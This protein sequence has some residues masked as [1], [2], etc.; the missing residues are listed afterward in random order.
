MNPVLE[1][2]RTRRSCKKYTDRPVAKE[3]VDQI[4][5]AGLWAASAM[6][7]QNVIILAVTE[8]KTRDAISLLN[9]KYDQQHRPD[10]FY[11]APA[12]LC[13]LAPKADGTAVHDG[14]LVMGNMM[15]AAH[16]LGVDN[17]WIHRAEEV[18][19]DPEGIEILR[20]AGI[21]GDYLGIGNLILGYAEVPNTTDKP[22][23][24]NRV[25]F[26]E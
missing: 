24:E 20:K 8:K 5:E 15:L 1:N 23:K 13:V 18:F 22:R 14:S 21:E 9:A 16:A 12:V 25:F 26:V 2:I 17:C 7:R 10:P 6:G 4:V 11:G 3:L 19:N